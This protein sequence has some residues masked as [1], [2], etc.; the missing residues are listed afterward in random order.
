MVNTSKILTVSYGTFSCTLEGFDDS[1]ETMKAIAEYFR[2]LAADDRYFGA[3]PP[4]PDADMLARIAEREIARRVEA[5]EDQGKIVLRAAETAALASSAEHATAPVAETPA[6]A[7]VT[8]TP[9]DEPAAEMVAADPAPQDPVEEPVAEMPAIA[10]PDPEPVAHA[11]PEYV[12]AV[13][14]EEPRDF[15][16][17][18]QVEES[19]ATDEPVADAD[20]V[21]EMANEQPVQDIASDAM[22]EDIA[23]Q[24]VD[25]SEPEP[26]T[27]VELAEETDAGDAPEADE[28]IETAEEFFENSPQPDASESYEADVVEEPVAPAASVDPES[29]A[30]KLNRIRSVVSQTEQT[31]D[32]GDYTE[33]EHAQDFLSDAAAELGAA[34][35]QDDEAELQ[36]AEQPAI[37]EIDIDPVGMID[38][39]DAAE[40]ETDEVEAVA[41][42]DEADD[43]FEDTLSQLLAD[44]IAEDTAEDAAEQDVTE[45]SDPELD[46]ETTMVDAEELAAETETETDDGVDDQEALVDDE[47]PTQHDAPVIEM[48][49]EETESEG[50][51]SAEEEEDLQTELAEVEAEVEAAD[52]EEPI[53][54][55]EDA[56]DT[57]EEVSEEASET[58]EEPVAEPEPE[59]E[60]AREGRTKLERAEGQT[61]IERIFDEA[62]NKLEQPESNQRRSAIQHLRAA[63]AATRA[64]KKAGVDLKKDVDDTP[65]R[66]DLAS[67]VRPRRPSAS[68]GIRSERPTT[69]GRPAPLK[70]VAEQRVDTDRE[71]VRPRR[72]SASE[73]AASIDGATSENESNFTQFAKEMGATQLPELLEAAAAYMADV[74]GRAQFSRPMLMHKL[75][76]VEQENFSR[77]DGL[78]SF[79]QL[80]REGK[81]QK[82][83][84]GRFTITDD[85]DFRNETRHAG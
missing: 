77:E 9:A 31:Y 81:I 83:K 59:A 47:A 4:T 14:A 25:L 60:H 54:V 40:P 23:A 69:E 50:H 42:E 55:E 62:D 70:L 15:V 46:D 24:P 20:P 16:F 29:V 63:V 49:A 66:S 67:V 58:M 39:S 22:A 19:P 17:S 78:R 84:G 82:I 32:Q 68:D 41:D 56:P 57:M 71:P 65:Y 64:E 36:N 1:F 52:A 5:H 27:P 74:E 8:E 10:T 30:A 43:G 26:E 72:V 3:E 61:D 48:E 12:A 33:D 45:T 79:G 11:A 35:A 38:T 75:Q 80:L 21:A 37:E 85:T 34:L 51:L 73:L 53:A 13:P 28:Y 44:S 18:E 6:E 2:D 76:E 7:P